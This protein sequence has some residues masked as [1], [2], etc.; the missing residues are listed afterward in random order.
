MG[1]RGRSMYK[2]R[3]YELNSY[4]SQNLNLLLLFCLTFMALDD[5]IS[6]NSMV[7]ILL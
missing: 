3:F 6:K 7:E 2:A 5:K 4:I 1:E